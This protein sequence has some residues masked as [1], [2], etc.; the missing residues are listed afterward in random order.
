M[1]GYPI[2]GD[3]I[4][5]PLLESITDQREHPGNYQEKGFHH[6]N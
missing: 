2:G 4:S 6:D 5:G 1:R 3:T